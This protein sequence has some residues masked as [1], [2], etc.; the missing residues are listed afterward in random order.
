MTCLDHP[1]AIQ[2]DGQMINELPDL[3]RIESEREF[4]LQWLPIR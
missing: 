3:A 1:P 4:E 2:I